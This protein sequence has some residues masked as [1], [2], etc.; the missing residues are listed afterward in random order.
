MKESPN[1]RR[2]TFPTKRRGQSQVDCH[3]YQIKIQVST[4]RGRQWR[5]KRKGDMPS[6]LQLI[7]GTTGEPQQL[8]KL[9]PRERLHLLIA[10][11]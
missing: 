7:K 3:R 9:I 5:S 2:R 11:L 6:V 1:D 8:K 10:S 4:G